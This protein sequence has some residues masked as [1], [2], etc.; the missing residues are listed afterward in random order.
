MACGRFER[1]YPAKHFQLE[2]MLRS[3]AERQLAKGMAESGGNGQFHLRTDH[4]VAEQ[5]SVI[6]VVI[7]LAGMG[8][9]F[10]LSISCRIAAVISRSRF[11]I[12]YD[13]TI[14]SQKRVT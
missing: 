8:E 3:E 13:F 2:P 10:R 6:E 7:V 1:H 9:F 14:K 4:D 11:R 12:G 5:L